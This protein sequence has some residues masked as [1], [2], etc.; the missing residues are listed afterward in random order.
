MSGTSR[1][2]TEARLQAPPGTR[3]SKEALMT[4]M[5]RRIAVA[6][7]VYGIFSGPVE[8]A[9]Q[10]PILSPNSEL[11]PYVVQATL[12]PGGVTDNISVNRAAF[13][14]DTVLVPGTG[15]VYRSEE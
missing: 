4:T 1:A 10:S 13:V 6:G 9:D 15:V 12:T 14:N 7:C 8:A 5:L 11:G 3:R 2:D